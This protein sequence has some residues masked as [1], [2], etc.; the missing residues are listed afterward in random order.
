MNYAL[1]G[2]AFNAGSAIN[3][4]R[5]GLKMIETPAQADQLAESVPGTDGVYFVPAFTGLG[6]PYWDMY[7]RG[8]LIGMTRGTTNAHVARAVLESIALESLD[9]IRC[10]ER[11]AGACITELR[12]DGGASKSRFL[13]Q[14]QSDI[15]G[16][17]V[18]RPKCVE[19]TALGAAMLAGLAVGVWESKEELSEIWQ[20]N[21]QFEPSMDAKEAAQRAEDWHRAVKR[22]M[23][24]AK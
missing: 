6:A 4:L 10:M 24:W 15:L 2:S 13:M 8:T 1:E 11:D 5:D 16:T 18:R 9:L 14:F 3:W 12:V 20:L 23:G 22:S 7:A 21:R 17:Y 19:T